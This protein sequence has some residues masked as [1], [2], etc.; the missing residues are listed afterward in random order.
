[1]KSLSL[2]NVFLVNSLFF[3]FVVF[4]FKFPEFDIFFS[5]MFFYEEQFISERFVYIKQLRSF[6]KNLMIIISIASLFL[7]LSNFIYKKKKKKSFFRMRM[8]LFLLGLIVGPVIGCGLIANLYFKDTWGRARPINIQE[9]GGDKIYTQAFVKSDQCERNC[10]WISGEASAAFSFI[11][12][13]II[14]K[15][16][17]FFLLNIFFGI[18]VSFCRIAMGGHF[19]SDNLFAM[20]FM[21][22]L[23]ILYKYFVFKIKKKCLKY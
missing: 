11:A 13:T 22:Y 10:S 17:I 23:A 8:K 6:L 7:L 18:I 3:F 19:L 5:K 12:G 16:P 21:I 14:I 15:N 4:F 2:K 9:F 20:I 1:M